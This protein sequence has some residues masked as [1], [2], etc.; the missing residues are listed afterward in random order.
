MAATR[1]GKKTV[2]TVK[3]VLFRNNEINQKFL[4]AQYVSDHFKV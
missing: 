1:D 3:N 4:Y 2:F